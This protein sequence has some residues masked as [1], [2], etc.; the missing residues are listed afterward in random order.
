MDDLEMCINYI[1]NIV[2][3]YMKEN[4]CSEEIAIKETYYKTKRGN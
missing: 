1:D 2:K 3:P 4:N